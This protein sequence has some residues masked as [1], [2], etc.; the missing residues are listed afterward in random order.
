MTLR[1]RAAKMENDMQTKNRRWKLTKIDSPHE[2]ASLISMKAFS[3]NSGFVMDNFLLLNDS[4]RRHE[5]VFAVCRQYIIYGSRDFQPVHHVDTFDF[6]KGSHLVP[7]TN[8]TV[9]RR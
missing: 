6:T 9:T 1:A 8:G 4:A 2:L 3:L 7:S 5:A